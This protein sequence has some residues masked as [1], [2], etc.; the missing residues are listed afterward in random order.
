MLKS[1]AFL[2]NMNN[3]CLPFAREMHQR[4]YNVKLFIDHNK[5]NALERPEFFD[6]GITY[7][8]PPW[9]EELKSLGFINFYK[10]RF[11]LL[12]FRKLIRR[13]NNFDIIVLN[14]MWIALAPFLKEEKRVVIIFAGFD[15]EIWGDKNKLSYVTD[16]LLE[17]R[18]SMKWVRPLVYLFCRHAINQQRKGIRRADAVNYFPT[19]V[20]IDGD[21]VLNAL[22]KNQN[23]E[24]LDLR[25][26]PTEHFPYVDN[27]DLNAVFKILNFTRF[28]YSDD[29]RNDNKRNDI[30]ILGIAK[31]L[32]AHEIKPHEIII[33]FYEKGEDVQLAKKL[34]SESGID[35]YIIWKAEVNQNELNDEI[36]TC[37]LV[38][39]QLGEQWI[40]YAMVA[41]L[42]GKP[43][44]AN[45]RPEV[46]E[47]ITG[48]KSPVCQA[49]TVDEVAEWLN[50]LYFDRELCKKTGKQCSDYYHKL[51]SI[52]KTIDFI[53]G[54]KQHADKP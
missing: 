29:S 46:F 47:K 20:N 28:F 8:Y 42:Y 51:H 34:I 21:N 25:G 52:G 17:K 6:K 24:K 1:V 11:P 40:G 33:E 53:I 36:K 32:K 15:L 48:E 31:F 9:I 50:K 54:V 2:G 43:A 10:L 7:P 19:G 45:C 22:K 16:I 12:F 26:F 44:I 39:D 41:M 49:K 4:N 13:L 18:K 37:H 30:M 35:E 3:L 14:G 23:F 38:F 5:T 27:F